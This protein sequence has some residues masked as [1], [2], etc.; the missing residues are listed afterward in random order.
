MA[1]GRQQRWMAEELDLLGVDEDN[2]HGIPRTP[3]LS[4]EKHF[5]AKKYIPCDVHC[6]WWICPSLHPLQ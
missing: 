3:A 2:Q 4:S 5:D 6:L 1:L